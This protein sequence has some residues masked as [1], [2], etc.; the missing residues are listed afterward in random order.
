M[1]VAC[2]GGGGALTFLLCAFYSVVWSFSG[3]W[4]RLSGWMGK[5]EEIVC[6]LSVC[7]KQEKGRE[8]EKERQRN[9]TPVLMVRVRVMIREFFSY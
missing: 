8:R 3:G 5:G 7:I 4:E 2:A 6:A 9:E 1:V